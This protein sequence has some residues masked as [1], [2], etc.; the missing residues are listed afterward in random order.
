M[1]FNIKGNTKTHEK[2]IRREFKIQPG[3]IFNS[4]KLERSIRDITILNY[5]GNIIP[6]VILLKM[7]ISM[8]I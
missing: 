5:F 7:M 3:D 2:V 8:L 1:K 6:N 4:S